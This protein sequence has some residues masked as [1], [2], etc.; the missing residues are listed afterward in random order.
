[1]KNIHHLQD[2]ANTCTCLLLPC[3]IQHISVGLHQLLEQR[4]RV[5]NSVFRKNQKFSIILFIMI[6]M[7]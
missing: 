7:N 2:L 1:M 4:L 6:M 3:K 5:S